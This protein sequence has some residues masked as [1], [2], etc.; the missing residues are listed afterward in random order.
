MIPFD[1]GLNEHKVVAR[2]I[3]EGK[4]RPIVAFRP[5]VPRTTSSSHVNEHSRLQISLNAGKVD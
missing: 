4:L 2:G 3:L 5:S 1:P